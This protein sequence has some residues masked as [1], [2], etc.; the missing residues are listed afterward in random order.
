MRSK[1]KS[2]A[3]S[4]I[5]APMRD[6]SDASDHSGVYERYESV[7]YAEY[8]EQNKIQIDTKPTTVTI[9]FL[10]RDWF[11]IKCSDIPKSKLFWLIL[12]LV[13]IIAGAAGGLIVYYALVRGS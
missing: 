5:E 12:L 1:Q 6:Q 13:L 11:L 8:E 2:Q 9:I 7:R 4:A 10:D 3:K